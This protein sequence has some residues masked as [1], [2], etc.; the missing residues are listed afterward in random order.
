MSSPVLVVAALAAGAPTLAYL[1]LVWWVDRYEKE[2]LH[3]LAVSF[4]WGVAPA[5]VLVAVVQT[6]LDMPLRA[7]ATPEFLLPAPH[8]LLAPLVE[9][10]VKGT[11]LLALYR[12]RRHE[13]NGVL[14]G[15]IYG[16]F[17][18]LGFALTENFLVYVNAFAS[19]DLPFGLIVVTTRGVLFGL[20]H[21][22]YTA[23]LGAGLGWARYHGHGPT[24]AIVPTLC[25]LG[26]IG[27]HL[28]HNSLA[29]GS[30]ERW[31]A[32]PLALVADWS[33]LAL[34]AALIALAWAHEHHWLEEGLRA[35]VRFGSISEGEYRLA[36]GHRRRA[37]AEWRA[38]RRGG[39]RRYR[40][41]ARHLH[42]LTE[43]AFARYH[44]ARDPHADAAAL[45]RLRRGVRQRRLDVLDRPPS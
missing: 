4:L 14:D 13:F 23:L 33:G 8:A 27:L 32:L 11:A 40:L 34:I 26:A 38:F 30:G 28:L 2:P 36:R 43:L 20:N 19:D 6:A 31:W 21:P 1:A 24:R 9:E 16:A 12:W 15:I 37:A 18:G 25:W 10:L 17:I 7:L 3:L 5:V 22:L 29:A 39:W 44:Q 45:E 35:E 42:A 41:V